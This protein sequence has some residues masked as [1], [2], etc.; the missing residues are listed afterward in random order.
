MRL[1]IDKVILYITFFGM[2]SI[3]TMLY[4]K[5]TRKDV[6]YVDLAK[7]I[8]GYKYKRDMEE[9]SKDKLLYIKNMIDSLK[10]IK[11][12]AGNGGVSTVDTQLARAEYSF[13]QYYVQSNQE[14]T[15]KVWDRLNPVLLQYGEERKLE[16]VIGANGA[17][18]LLYG[19]KGKD[20]TDDLITYI[21]TRYEKGN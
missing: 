14:I 11:N 8:D 16:M 3:G 1:K 7:M 5:N 2:L 20:V 6:V 19:S 21:N 10:L 17:G 9:L 13:N 18:T 4:L 12:V 15:K